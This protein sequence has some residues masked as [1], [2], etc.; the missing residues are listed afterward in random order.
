MTASGEAMKAKVLLLGYGEMG[1]AFASLLRDRVELTIW[2]RH[3]AAGEVKM[4]V[5]TA[6]K[7]SD[8]VIFCLPAVAHEDVL[9]QIA[10]NLSPHTIC[11]SIAK[12]LDEQGRCVAQIFSQYLDHGN[13]RGRYA[14][15]YGPM[16][17]EELSAGRQGFAELAAW[18]ENILPGIRVLFRE[19]RLVLRN[20]HDV[21][22]CS[23]A[24]ILKN[25][26]ALLF[27]MVDGL[28]LGDNVRGYLSVSALQELAQIVVTMGGQ[29]GTAYSLAG[30]G[31][32]ITTATSRNSHHHALGLKL[33][34]GDR[35]DVRG[36]G[37]HTLA[38]V[39]K[40]ALLELAPYPLFALADAI[41]CGGMEPARAFER[42][43]IEINKS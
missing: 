33:A 13:E 1:H 18:H 34:A 38:M 16:I 8:V 30:L 37:V 4:D 26:Y 11:M 32:L 27:G 2:Q 6:V 24:V 43:L 39:R 7:A 21:L 25:V 31:D 17:A 20:T 14:F 40:H 29:A 28:Q 42:H 15:L 22:G 41:V 35:T 23:W 9:R 19:T 5:A 10:P 12:G 3:P 36:E